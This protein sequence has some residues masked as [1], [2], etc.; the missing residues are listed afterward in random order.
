MNDIIL[1]KLIFFYT[2]SLGVTQTDLYLVKIL[3]AE[4][5]N[6]FKAWIKYNPFHLKGPT[7]D[8]INNGVF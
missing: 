6:R 3:M 8:L 7:S 4:S 2:E 1:N 5:F